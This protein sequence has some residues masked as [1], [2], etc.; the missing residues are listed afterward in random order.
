MPSPKFHIDEKCN[1]AIINLIKELERLEME[2]G[3]MSSLLI[4]APENPNE[5]IVSFVGG[6]PLSDE[7]SKMFDTKE[8]LEMTLERR[9]LLKNQ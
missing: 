4:I 8:L 5:Q 3:G 1:E 6:K 2:S 7:M 9:E